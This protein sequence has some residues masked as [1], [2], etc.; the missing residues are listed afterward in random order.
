M[1]GNLNLKK[2]PCTLDCGC[3]LGCGMAGGRL[4]WCFDCTAIHTAIINI[5]PWRR[6]CPQAALTDTRQLALKSE[7][8]VKTVVSLAV[9]QRRA[10]QSLALSAL[11]D[12][13][14]AAFNETAP[15]LGGCV[16]FNRRTCLV[17]CADNRLWAS[18]FGVFTSTRCMS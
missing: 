13:E 1:W 6:C 14:L 16:D 17:V 4:S 18:A 12:P 3:A 8:E 5:V 11:D 15:Q 10:T 2:K 7:D 9:Q